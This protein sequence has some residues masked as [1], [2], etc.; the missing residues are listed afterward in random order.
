M[1]L[2]RKRRTVQT[3]YQQDSD[4]VAVVVRIACLLMAVGAEP[5]WLGG[6]ALA[7]AGSIALIAVALGISP[8][9]LTELLKGRF[10]H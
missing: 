8:V 6:N 7:L 10:G 9:Q 1:T 4:P 5:S 2:Q 3:T